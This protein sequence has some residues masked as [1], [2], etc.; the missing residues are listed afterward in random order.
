MEE[1]SESRGERERVKG[2]EGG[3]WERKKWEK[4]LVHA[5]IVLN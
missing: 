3:R 4:E 2:E 1:E 5:R